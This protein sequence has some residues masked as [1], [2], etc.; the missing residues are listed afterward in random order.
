MQF[1]SGIWTIF[2]T[3]NF[4]TS[5]ANRKAARRWEFTTPCSA[6]TASVRLSGA[7]RLNLRARV[8][9]ARVD[10]SAWRMSNGKNNSN[11]APLIR[12]GS[13]PKQPPLVRYALEYV[14]TEILE[15]DARSHDQVFYCRGHEYLARFCGRRYARP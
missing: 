14:R 6:T 10:L 9:G 15:M 3:R 8:K 2:A 5:P 1:Q 13:Q 12:L 4:P 11:P 7:E